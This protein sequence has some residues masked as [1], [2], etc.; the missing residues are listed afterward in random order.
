MPRPPQ[1]TA[2]QRQALRENGRSPVYLVDAETNTTYALIPAADYEAVAGL[3]G[4]ETFDIRETYAA[5]E[6]VASKAGWDD[7]ALDVYNEED[8][9]RRT[10]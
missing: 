4:E 2:A 6:A 3:L 8:A 9:P 7:P 10:A 5:Q 1:L